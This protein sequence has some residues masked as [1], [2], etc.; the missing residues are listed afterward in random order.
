[1]GFIII[2]ISKIN[3]KTKGLLTSFNAI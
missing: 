2:Y 3:E 1:M